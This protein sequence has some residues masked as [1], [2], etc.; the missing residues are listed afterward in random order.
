[1]SI[2]DQVRRQDDFFLVY[3][4]TII[5]LEYMHADNTKRITQ[6]ELAQQ[7]GVSQAT[8]SRAL[9]KNSRHS[10]KMRKQVSAV[11]ERL[12]YRPDPVLASLNAYRRMQRPISVG[13]SLAWFGGMPHGEGYDPLLYQAARTRAETLGYG[14]EYFWE[15]EPGYSTRRY[16]QIFNARGIAGVIF[17]PRQQA[18]ARIELSIDRLAAVTVGRSVDWPPVDRV[19]VDHFQTMEACYKAV[20]EHGFERIGFSMTGSYNERVAGLWAGAFLGQQLRNQKLVRIPP[21][22]D[23]DAHSSG[24]FEPWFRKWKP[25][26]ILTMGWHFGCLASLRQMG[27]RFPQDIGVA[28]LVVPAHVPEKEPELRDFSGI[29]EPDQELAAFAV[30]VLVGRIRNNERGVPTERR[31]HLLPGAWIDGKTLT[32][33]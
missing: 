7:L 21:L 1:M 31:V 15:Y 9:A 22:L 29:S 4:N 10:E 23:D 6:K 12:G 25:D 3:T 30:D 24:K 14:L 5:T 2:G 20:R 8:I 27:V 13:Q 17:G 16:T 28:L 19:S 11:A 18:H 33:A 26:A 32:V